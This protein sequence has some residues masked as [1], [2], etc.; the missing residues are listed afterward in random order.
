MEPPS[1]LWLAASL[2]SEVRFKPKRFVV[3]AAY[4]RACC[5]AVLKGSRLHA[6]GNDGA[7]LMVG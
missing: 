3:L 1:D 6:G 7:V 2:A 4:A 5:I